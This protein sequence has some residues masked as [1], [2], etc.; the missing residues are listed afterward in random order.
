MVT[1]KKKLSRCPGCL[2]QG[3]IGVFFIVIAH[4]RQPN[5]FIGKGNGSS[6]WRAG[7]VTVLD[8]S[9][10]HAAN[11]YGIFVLGLWTLVARA[12]RVDTG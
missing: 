3:V 7:R 8:A 1:A 9:L 12:Q 2:A 10:F 6:S 4:R 11:C 5:L